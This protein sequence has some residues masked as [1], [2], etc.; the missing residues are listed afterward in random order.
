[1]LNVGLLIG[2]SG[3]KLFIFFFFLARDRK[4]IDESFLAKV[5]AF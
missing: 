3:T 4:G 5:F 2:N 1:M